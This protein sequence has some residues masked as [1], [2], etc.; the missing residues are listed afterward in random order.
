[1]AINRVAIRV[2]EG[3]HHIPSDVIDR[4]YSRGIQNLFQIYIPLCDNWMLFDN[5]EQPI[6]IAKGSIN[7]ETEIFD[8]FKWEVISNV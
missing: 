7:Q 2:S 4:R 5:E 8:I 6:I 3:G 1:M